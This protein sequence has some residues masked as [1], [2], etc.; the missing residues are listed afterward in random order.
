MM[1]T[2]LK[3]PDAFAAP[4]KRNTMSSS[5]RL[6]GLAAALLLAPGLHA[7]PAASGPAAGSAA[8]A[9]SASAAALATVQAPD[10][11]IRLLSQ[12]VL[13][14]IRQEPDLRAGDLRRVSRFV[15]ESVMP[16]VDFERM[17]ALA[18][19]RGW[20]Q[21][22]PE[23]QRQ[24]MAEFR[25]LLV[26]TYA[27]AVSHVKDQQIRLK[28]QRP[29]T[30]DGD[31]IVRSEIL[32]TRGEPIQIDYRMSRTPSGWKIYDL[33]VLGVWLVESYRNQFAQE[34]SAKGIDGLIRS[35]SERNRQFAQAKP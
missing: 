33:N 17:T 25:V 26:R 23:Q 6:I 30:E 15:N 2:L 29:A 35:L 28:P 32:S 13:D 22:S 10:E 31:A 11:F 20:R 7:Q 34:V 5:L 19:G 27:G 21:A 4:M 3:R 9:T 16:Y 14:R 8:S 1:A 18:V 24:L 12:T